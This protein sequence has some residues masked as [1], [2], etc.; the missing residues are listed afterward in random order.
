MTQPRQYQTKSATWWSMLV[1]HEPI[2]TTRE[3]RTSTSARIHDTWFHM[4]RGLHVYEGAW[5]LHCFGKSSRHSHTLERGLQA[6]A[7]QAFG[8]KAA[9]ALLKLWRRRLR[10]CLHEPQ[11]LME[12]A[13]QDSGPKP[14]TKSRWSTCRP[15]TPERSSVPFL[16][17]CRLRITPH[18][19]NAVHG[20]NGFHLRV[21]NVFVA[22][23]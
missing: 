16:S 9:K 20:T 19:N 1:T 23:C 18:P 2:A 17:K 6:A 22:L 13:P 21:F 11:H 3:A 12:E 7:A 10:L 5:E 14:E 8:Q 4:E 15:E